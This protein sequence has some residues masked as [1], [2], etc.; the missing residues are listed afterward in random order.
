[1][2]LKVNI[3]LKN[4]PP[5]A[6]IIL[7]ILPGV[8]IVA[9]VTMLLILP[10]SKE[11][12]ALDQKIS[13]QE[14]EIA[15]S[16][17]KVAKLGELSRENERL[18]RRLEELQQLLPEEKEVS[19]LLKQVSDLCI[20]SGLKVALWKPENKKTHPSGIVYEIPVKVELTG[21]YH[22]LG[23]FFGSLTGL[24]RI[25]NI[26]DIKLSYPSTEKGITT[27]KITFAATTFSAIPEE[28]R[29]GEKL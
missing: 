1:M 21:S 10:R 6:R 25:V 26:S 16:Q 4:L 15:K 20:K 2:A 9:L 29:A 3:N 14:N 18:R 7:S 23:F 8:V 5:Y 22:S 24:N 11:I 19:G 27:L 13:V 12:R 17:T 28:E